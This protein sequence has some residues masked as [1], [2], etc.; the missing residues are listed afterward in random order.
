[1]ASKIGLLKSSKMG[2]YETENGYASYRTIIDYFCGNIVLCNNIVSVDVSIYENMNNNGLYYYN[3]ETNEEATQEDYNN[4]EKGIIE[5]EYP[6]I[7]QYFICNLTDYNK[8][9][10]EKAGVILSYSNMLECDIL[11]VEHWGT[12]W[13]YVLTNV[14]L[15]D[16]YEDLKAYE[17]SNED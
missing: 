10:L 14:K 1:M 8:E 7:Y 5:V 9:Q 2:D 4:D 15:F 16:T 11:C 6:E 12:S 3:T 13:D 17:E